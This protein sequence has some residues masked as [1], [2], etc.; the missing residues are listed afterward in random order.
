MRR[1]PPHNQCLDGDDL[2]AV[3]LD[4][5]DMIAGRDELPP[6]PDEEPLPI[7]DKDGNLNLE[8]LRKMNPNYHPCDNEEA[9]ARRRKGNDVCFPEREPGSDIPPHYDQKSG[10]WTTRVDERRESGGIEYVC[11]EFA[12]KGLIYPFRTDSDETA[13]HDHEHTFAGVLAALLD[14]PVSFSLRGFEE[15]YSKQE[16]EMLCKVQEKLLVMKK[17][18]SATG[19]ES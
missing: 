8:G 2:R 11:A 14:S 16:L 10:Q 15:Y 12:K 6:D 7:F 3:L 19:T 1:R 9:A 13:W 18:S 17:S 4:L 5:L